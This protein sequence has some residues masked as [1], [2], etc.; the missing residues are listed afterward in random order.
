MDNPEPGIL[1]IGFE[2]TIFRLRVRTGPFTRVPHLLL[3]H[4]SLKEE[5]VSSAQ[6][7]GRLAQ[8]VSDALEEFANEILAGSAD[9]APVFT[10]VEIPHARGERQ[11]VTLELPGLQSEAGMKTSEVAAGIQYDDPNTYNTLRALERAGLVELVPDASPQRW[12]LAPRYRTT[13]ATFARVA[14]R[15]RP[16]EWSTY[17][18][19]SIVTRGDLKAAHA[20]GQAAATQL[21]FP[22]PWRVLKEGG[23]IHEHWKD[24]EGRGPEETRRRLEAEGVKFDR[25]GRACKEFRVGWDVLL[26]R[27]DQE[28][29]GE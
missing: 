10:E 8:A 20:V 3:C 18:D 24:A 25:D 15:I 5:Q 22:H 13:A 2:L 16:S 27:N 21:D 17:G 11:Q 6:A 19:I 28:P 12:R 26:E 23:F 14:S 1:D 29:F 4:S 9:E 7:V